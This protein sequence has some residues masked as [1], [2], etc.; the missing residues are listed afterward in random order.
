MQERVLA[1]VHARLG[2]QLHAPGR[3][4]TVR[5]LDEVELLRDLG[6]ERRDVGAA[7]VEQAGQ[8]ATTTGSTT[9]FKRFSPGLRQG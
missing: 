9:T 5:V 2:R 6:K 4:R 3:E 8:R 7:Q 1:R